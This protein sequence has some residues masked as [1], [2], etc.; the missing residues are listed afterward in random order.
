LNVALVHANGIPGKVRVPDAG[1]VATL[2][3]ANETLG[4]EYLRTPRNIVRF[5]F[6]LLNLLDQNPAR[7][8][9][10]ILEHQPLHA[11]GHPLCIEEDLA[12]GSPPAPDEDLAS[13]RL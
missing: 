5:F 7:N 6:S 1:I 2:R 13:V 11:P 4:S 8:W 9:S 3:K 10:D 12:N